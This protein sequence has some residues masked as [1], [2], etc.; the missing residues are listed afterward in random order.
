MNNQFKNLKSCPIIKF[1]LLFLLKYIFFVS[2][3]ISFASLLFPSF[4]WGSLNV[5][6]YN[7]NK[8]TDDEKVCMFL[9]VVAQDY[10]T[11]VNQE[12]VIQGND[13][14]L[15]CGIPSFVADFLQI[16]SWEDDS[17]TALYADNPKNG[18]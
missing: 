4:Y 2:I 13:V 8:N 16:I 15:K 11:H 17:G 1:P 14:I 12:Y 3:T 10:A 18:N 7:A 5:V 6:F 9:L